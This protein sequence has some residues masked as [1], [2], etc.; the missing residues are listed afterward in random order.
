MYHLL[1]YKK[2]LLQV[3]VAGVPDDPPFRKL[4]TVGQ[5][6]DGNHFSAQIK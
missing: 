3:E 2:S 4:T 5:T 1:H 6:V